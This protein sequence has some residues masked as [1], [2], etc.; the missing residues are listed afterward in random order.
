MHVN[1]TH[2]EKYAD[3]FLFQLYIY[4]YD[5]TVVT[6]TL[7]RQIETRAREGGKEGENQS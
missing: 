2:T 4:K 5:Y 3:L 1:A 7:L 6:G